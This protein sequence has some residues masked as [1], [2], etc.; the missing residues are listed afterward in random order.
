MPVST[1]PLASSAPSRFAFWTRRF[2]AVLVIFILLGAIAVAGGRI[3][4]HRALQVSLP[5]LDGNIALAG[6]QDPVRV[7]RSEHGIPH[8]IAANMDDLIFAQGFVTAQD[9]LWQMD[10]LRRHAAGEL[11]EVL[12]SN[13]IQHDRLQRTLQVRAAAD[14]AITQLDP[15]ERHWLDVYARGIN[16]FV[17]ANLNRLPAEFRIL[18]YTPR[19][20]TARDS[21]LVGFAMAE[22]LSTGYPDKL[23]RET[24]SAKLDPALQADLYPVGSWRDH[25][26]AEGKPDLTQPTPFEPIPLDS[27]QAALRTPAHTQDLLALQHE[28]ATYVS[29]Y[30]CDG[31]T[32]GSN[33]WTISGAHTANGHPLLSNDMHLALGIPGIWYEADLEAGDFHAAG[34]TLPG[35][36]F[37]IMGHNQH[38]AWGF[39][40]SDADVQDVYIENIAN[41]RYQTPDG[42]WHPL[43]HAQETIHVKHSSDVQ[44]DVA[45][46]QHNGIP[47]PILTPLYPHEKR[48]LALQWVI[49][50][51]T[52]AS[53]PFYRVDKAAN[54]DEFLTAFQTFGAPSQNV[55]YADDAG[56]IGYHLIGKVPLRGTS[57]LAPVAVASG[58]YEWT[59]YIPFD[60]LPQVF[61][62]PS[63]IIATANA[64]ITPDDYDL[65]ITL[66]WN[67]PYRNERIWKVLGTDKKFTAADMLALQNDVYSDFDKTL[68]QR[69]SY[70]VDHARNPSKRLRQAA[71]ILRNWNGQVTIDS[72]APSIVAA[73]TTALW[74]MLLEPHLGES[75]KLYTWRARSFALE[76]IVSDAPMRWLPKEYEDWN[77]FLTA[78]LDRGLNTSRAPSNLASWKW[79]DVNRLEIDHPLFGKTPLLRRLIGMQTGTGNWPL[80]GNGYTVRPGLP[81]N[82]A[83]ERF[84][85]DPTDPKN[86]TM[87]IPLGQSSNPL[88]PWYM[89]QFQSWLH[90]GTLP[91]PFDTQQTSHTLVLTPQ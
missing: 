66:D 1:A 77:E 27:S 63:S 23:N 36:P 61:D 13:F 84:T 78:A 52:N 14:R 89:D 15:Q 87:I 25:P 8:I 65:P 35:V 86:A 58:N 21:L 22:D 2:A 80:P 16:A 18:G 9:R 30:R 69:I 56:H 88:S 90:Q 76:Q 81:K 59:G 46:T 33:N 6:L 31:C 54:W 12:G 5:V 83:S 34:V 28:I 60:K 3:W 70:A 29:H 68:A 50:D 45:L 42:G 26:P 11:A 7:E 37:I 44:W 24:V 74:P 47:T 19:P 72:P 91:L 48:Q 64:R 79:G 10:M 82:G 38:I 85:V 4:L 67:A 17:D 71:D 20:W 62:P 55:V 40:N 57:G 32:A 51:P 73:T 75:W 39:T 41:D 49:Y 43:Q 53:A